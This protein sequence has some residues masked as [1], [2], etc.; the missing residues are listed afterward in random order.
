MA[1]IPEHLLRRSQ[2]RRQ[3]LAGGGVEGAE[4]A[5]P[6]AGEDEVPGG[7]EHAAQET[8]APADHV[9]VRTR[10][11]IHDDGVLVVPEVLLGA[12]Q[13]A[14]AVGAH[15]VRH[16]EFHADVGEVRGAHLEGL[17][18]EVAAQGQRVV[19]PQGRR[20]AAEDR[21]ARHG[22]PRELQQPVQAHGE[23]VRE[24]LAVRADA[25]GVR[26]VQ[27]LVGQADHGAGVAD[28]HG[29]EGESRHARHSRAALS[30]PVRCAA[31]FSGGYGSVRGS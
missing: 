25:P 14:Q 19:L 17:H 29:Q 10:P 13:V 7:G 9:E 30:G 31:G 1:E 2:E 12:E 16:V 22:C 6:L 4:Q 15:G 20:D 26:E 28:V 27:L 3:A 21:R 18:G 11:E 8:A 23:V 5:V 24:V